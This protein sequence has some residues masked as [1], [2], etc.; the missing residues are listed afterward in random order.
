M[1]NNSTLLGDWSLTADQ[2]NLI[3]L[4]PVPKKSLQDISGKDSEDCNGEE[5]YLLIYKTCL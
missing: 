2:E 1:S 3:H 4:S 5:Q